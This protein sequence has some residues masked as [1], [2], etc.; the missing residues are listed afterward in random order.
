MTEKREDDLQPITDADAAWLI[1]RA[2]LLDAMEDAH[3]NVA[4]LR[5]AAHEAGISPAAF[6]RAL[7]EVRVA[8]PV[9]RKRA[10]KLSEITRRIFTNFLPG[11]LTTLI[12]PPLLFKP[13]TF[14]EIGP[15]QVGL[16]TIAAAA[17][18]TGHALASFLLRSRTDTRMAD[19]VSFVVGA[20]VPV[21]FVA[22]QITGVV[23]SPL[24]YDKVALIWAELAAALTLIGLGGV[25]LFERGRSATGDATADAATK[26]TSER[27]GPW[28]RF[29]RLAT[30][31]QLRWPRFITL[32]PAG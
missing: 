27:E 12:V 23:G 2:A 28:S 22:L 9:N 30:T 8:H 32:T 25:R 6:E 1:E 29:G 3:T 14:L 20:L 11:W 17:A 31:Q 19:R 26:A 24:P 5:E 10:S 15:V 7:Q 4:R 21:A 13:S 16:L 18:V